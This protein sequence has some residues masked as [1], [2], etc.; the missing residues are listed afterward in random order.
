MA[1][2]RVSRNRPEIIFGFRIVPWLSHL[3]EGL[4]KSVR[5]ILVEK[6]LVLLLVQDDT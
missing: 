4:E 5:L 2:K 1:V 3:D 6:L